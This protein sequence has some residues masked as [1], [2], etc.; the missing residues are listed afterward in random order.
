MITDSGF[1][2]LK[3]LL[4]IRKRGGY[5]S[6]FIKKYY[7]DLGGFLETLLISTS[8]KIRLVLWGVLVV[9][10]MRQS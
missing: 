4:E 2:L 8:V 3:G 6:E 10:G 1:C 7:I 9:N 5:G